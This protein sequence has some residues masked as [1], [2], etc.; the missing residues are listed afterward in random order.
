MTTNISSS[1]I[2]G[3]IVVT[4]VKLHQ[5]QILAVA[6]ANINTSA[7]IS[8]NIG[9]NTISKQTNKKSQEQKIHKRRKQ[10]K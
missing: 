2:G 5:Y 10:Q 6:E 3:K 7:S 4:A 1:K 8:A 9:K